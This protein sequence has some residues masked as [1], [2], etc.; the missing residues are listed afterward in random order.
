MN[1]NNPKI[2][3]ILISVGDGY[4]VQIFSGEV[5]LPQLKV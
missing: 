5:T 1:T 4:P 2:N 3:I